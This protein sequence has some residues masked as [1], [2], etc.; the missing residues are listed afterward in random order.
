MFDTNPILSSIVCRKNYGY[1][2]TY[3]TDDMICA[4]EVG[5]GKDACQGDSGGP[6]VTANGDDGVS[7][8]QNYE[9]IGEKTRREIQTLKNLT[10]LQE[11]RAGATAAQRLTIPGSMRGTADF[12]D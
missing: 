11:L 1:D 6:M 12:L 9:L 10:S 7:P 2:K 4:N 3:I 5:G 8:G